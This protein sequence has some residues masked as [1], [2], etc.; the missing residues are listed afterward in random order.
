M[1]KDY[2]YILQDILNTLKNIQEE[3]EELNE[4]EGD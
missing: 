2:Y 3:L 1:N 4:K